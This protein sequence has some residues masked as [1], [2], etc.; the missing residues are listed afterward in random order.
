M[1]NLEVVLQKLAEKKIAGVNSYATVNREMENVSD[2]MYN[3]LVVYNNRFSLEYDHRVKGFV[4]STTYSNQVV[5]GSFIEEMTVLN[6][7]KELL[8][9]EV[10]K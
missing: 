3:A 2:L 7:A 9:K 8:N 10:S 6:Q 4:L 1:K 5:D